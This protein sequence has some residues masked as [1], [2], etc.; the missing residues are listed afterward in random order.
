MEHPEWKN[1]IPIDLVVPYVDSSDPVWQKS[2][3]EAIR[4][5]VGGCSA[6]RFRSNGTF[7]YFFRGVE[8]NMP[9]I[10]TIH[11]VLSGPS[12]IPSWLNTKNPK[13]HIVYH[14]DYIP[15]SELPTFNSNVIEMFYHK[16]PGLSENFII[17]NDDW[18]VL[19]PT[20]EY[21]FFRGDLP[22]DTDHTSKPYRKKASL[23][24]FYTSLWHNNE[25][26][27]ALFKTKDFPSYSVYHRF[28]PM[29]K[30]MIEEVW[31][32][33]GKVIL[34]GI[35]KSCFR[36]SRNF[37]WHLF[38]SFCLFKG[39]FHKDESP[40]CSYKFIAVSSIKEAD[41]VS[42]ANKFVCL[43]DCARN[44]F[45]RIF[46]SLQNKL[47][48]YFPNESHF[49]LDYEEE[50][51]TILQENGEIKKLY[52][53][54]SF[55]FGRYDKHREPL[56]IDPCCEY[57]YVTDDTNYKSDKWKVIYKK[58]DKRPFD[59]A[60]YV[61]YHPFEFV[62]TDTCIILDASLSIRKSLRHLYEKFRE[63]GYS[64]ALAAN[65][66]TPGVIEEIDSW[67]CVSYLRARMTEWELAKLREMAEKFLPK[68]YKGS[69]LAGFQIATRQQDSVNF[70]KK[71]WEEIQNFG[72]SVRLDEVL[73][74]IVFYRFFANTDFMRLW[75]QSYSNRRVVWIKHGTDMPRHMP[76]NRNN[77]FWLNER[78]NPIDV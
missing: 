5:H 68:G 56:V 22:V 58:V 66:I 61:R 32:R 42:L 15:K 38:R 2:F 62:S 43:N 4:H 36:L 70:H 16:I 33:A 53:I 19:K 3:K 21:D 51:D 30:S 25:L 76:K 40:I 10:R 71:M 11:L 9:W 48:E 49:E 27:K 1:T 78:I 46:F 29:K 57:V 31:R 17:A 28:A 74:A 18:F 6:N 39:C 35:G 8:Q 37:T 24:D 14:K 26:L 54:L 72:R 63:G 65:N 75:G 23:Y 34:N 59:A 50:H 41:E 67:S 13:L 20:T 73:M 12:Q 64:H 44:N 60:L 77:V 69:F 47:L 55:N 52:S 45:T 7:K